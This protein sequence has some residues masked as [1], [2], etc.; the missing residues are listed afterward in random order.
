MNLGFTGDIGELRNFAAGT[1]HGLGAGRRRRRLGMR[2]LRQSHL[3]GQQKQR[4]RA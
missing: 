1:F 3:S 4:E 2:L